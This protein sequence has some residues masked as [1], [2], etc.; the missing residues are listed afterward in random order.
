M[1]EP[2]GASPGAH[3][4]QESG[5]RGS[6][7]WIT[8]AITP[9]LLQ[10]T[11]V[12]RRVYSGRTPFQKVEIVDT[13]S[14]GRV[15]LLDG[16]TQ[17]TEADEFV[18][19]ESL[20]HPVLL[21]IPKPKRVFIGGGGEGATLR[22][23]LR[24]RSVEEAVMVDLDAEVVALCREHLT[25]WHQGAFDDPRTTLVHDDALAFLDHEQT[26]FDALVLDLVDPMEAGPAYKLYTKEFYELAAS[27]LT[28]DGALVI[29]SGPAIAGTIR[30]SSD[31]EDGPGPL[32]DLTRGFT[33]LH[34]TLSQVF[35]TVVGY[36]ATIPAFGGPWSFLIA[37]NGHTDPCTLDPALVDQRLAE[38]VGTPMG[39]YDG[40]SHQGM[41]ALPKP[42]RA[43]LE[44]ET[45]IV[46]EE[47]PLLVP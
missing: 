26:P 8:E 40:I 37:S 13:V 27:K 11:E 16:K 18:Y 44:S 32:T 33:A 15:F 20:V 46:T 10:L 47:H 43:A 17:S 36:T 12:S 4:R 28:A 29:Q 25:T 5:A 23:V 35:P 1:S 42:L 31:R 2:L 7:D 14:F 45:W 9:N 34:H 22:E 19:H 39:H 24:H 30:P 3:Q 6:R 41:F 38:R 21:S